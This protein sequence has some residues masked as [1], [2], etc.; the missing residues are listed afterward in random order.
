M[1]QA[2]PAAAVSSVHRPLEELLRVPL[3][4]RLVPQG[5]A[6]QQ[7]ELPLLV[8]LRHRALPW[9]EEARR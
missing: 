2:F 3:G 1:A 9:L 5:A 8:A 7:R 4:L 6:A